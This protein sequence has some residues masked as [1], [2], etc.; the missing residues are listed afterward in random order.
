[1]VITGSITTHSTATEYTQ[2]VPL[3]IPQYST[4]ATFLHG[5]YVALDAESHWETSV[6]SVAPDGLE[7][8]QGLVTSGM[9]ERNPRG[10]QETRAVF[11]GACG[12]QLPQH[13]TPTVF[14]S[15]G[16]MVLG[17][18]QDAPSMCSIQRDCCPHRQAAM[19][20]RSS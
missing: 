11:P 9:L 5:S 20:R 3:A 4:A 15:T 19:A 8:P 16:S 1:M 12:S 6:W 17:N 10:C 2:S 7:H 14:Y 13:P 18:A